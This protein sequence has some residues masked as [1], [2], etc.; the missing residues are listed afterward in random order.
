MA[1]RIEITT[2]DDLDG[3]KADETVGFAVDG[4]AYEVDLN[5]ENASALR[6][7]LAR[8]TEAGRK[9]PMPIRKRRIKGSAS[10]NREHSTAVREWARARGHKVSDR[11]RIP[12]EITALYDSAHHD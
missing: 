1:E 12:A 6:V 11:G 2:I 4:Q 8:Y 10:R 7:F 5:T 3:S 9:V